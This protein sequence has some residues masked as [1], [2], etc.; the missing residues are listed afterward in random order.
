MV[1]LVII[2]EMLIVMMVNVTATTLSVI[3]CGVGKELEN[4][5]IFVMNNIMEMVSFDKS[6]YS[7]C[8]SGVELVFMF[9]CTVSLAMTTY[10]CCLFDS[11]L[12]T[13]TPTKI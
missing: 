5:K 3:L 2:E 10:H 13:C 4:L 7:A 11:Q 6:N 9:F 8:Q 12:T 1:L